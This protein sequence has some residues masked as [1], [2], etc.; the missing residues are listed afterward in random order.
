[1]IFDP[2]IFELIIRLTIIR[3][4]PHHETAW[5]ILNFTR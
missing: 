2:V 1:M 3:H 5:P 4:P